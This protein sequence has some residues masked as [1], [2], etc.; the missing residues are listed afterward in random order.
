M[1]GLFP[2]HVQS[3]LSPVPILYCSRDYDEAENCMVLKQV[4]LKTLI[5]FSIFVCCGILVGYN[6]V[7]WRFRGARCL[8]CHI[9][10]KEHAYFEQFLVLKYVVEIFSGLLTSLL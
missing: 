5:C 4:S 8:M 10:G 3:L 2:L 1:L 7:L 9:S 6:F